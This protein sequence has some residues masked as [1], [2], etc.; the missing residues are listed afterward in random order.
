MSLK[1]RNA[2]G[3][4]C[5]INN[6]LA[7]W[8]TVIKEF[9]YLKTVD[10]HLLFEI[11]KVYSETK[12]SHVFI[13]NPNTW[14]KFKG[15]TNS[16][17]RLQGAGAVKQTYKHIVQFLEYQSIPFTPTRLQ[18]TFKK[19]SQETFKNITKY[20]KSTNEHSRD[21]GMLVFNK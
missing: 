15:T 5:G 9:V 3:I 4:D 20:D 17:S 10:L 8:D 6:G 12:D 21:A 11:V 7:I 19:L 14:V 13:E 18:G 2:I 16:N 1:F